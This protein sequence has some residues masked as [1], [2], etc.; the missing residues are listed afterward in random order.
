MKRFVIRLEKEDNVVIARHDLEKG[1]FLEEEGF[2]LLE[3]IPAGYKIAARD[4]KKGEEI[5]KYDTVIGYASCDIKQGEMIHNHNDEFDAR[6]V[7]YAYG[8]DCHP[9]DLLPPEQRRTC[10]GRRPG[11]YPQLYRDPGVQQLR[12]HRGS[13]DQRAF[14]CQIS[15]ALPQC[16]RGGP[17]HHRAGLRHGAV[18]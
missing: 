18:R 7:D 5:R 13:E 12:R 4:L 11:G 15:G 8:A 16:G 6:G 2:S 14:R 1:L 17:L 10:L 3:D 9:V